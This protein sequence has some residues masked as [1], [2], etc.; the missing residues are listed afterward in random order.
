MSCAL[1]VVAD[2]CNG[3]IKLTSSR[4]EAYE[5]NAIGLEI[6]ARQNHNPRC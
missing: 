2:Q 6:T 1:R 3:G 5:H 4:L